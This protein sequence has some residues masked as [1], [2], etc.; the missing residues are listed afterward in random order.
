MKIR[1]LTFSRNTQPSV[2]YPNVLDKDWWF[3]VRHD[4]RSKYSF[5]N[6][7]II[8]MSSEK[9][10]QGDGNEVLMCTCFI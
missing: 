5:E 3:T 2:F 8:N 1:R 6:N 9:D 4:T 7:N 10:N